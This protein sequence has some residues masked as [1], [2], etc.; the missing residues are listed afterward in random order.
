M[1]K[2]KV[3]PS[4]KVKKQIKE[5]LGNIKTIVFSLFKDLEEKGPRQPNWPNYSKLEKY[6]KLVPDNSHHCHLKKGNPTYVACWC[7]VDKNKRLIEVFYVGTHENA[8]YP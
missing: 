5:L 6:K 3:E 7:V 2:W 8:P 4:N 1:P